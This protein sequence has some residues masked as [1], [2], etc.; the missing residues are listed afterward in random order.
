LASRNAVAGTQKPVS[1]RLLALRLVFDLFG[2]GVARTFL[3]LR[4]GDALHRLR[5]RLRLAELPRGVL[6]H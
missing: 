2:D 6:H 5:R 1:D 3:R 4:L